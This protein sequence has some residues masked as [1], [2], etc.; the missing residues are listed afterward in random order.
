MF[1]PSDRT[2]SHSMPPFPP[3]LRSFRGGKGEQQVDQGLHPQQ[4]PLVMRLGC[5]VCH[6]VLE[7]TM[8]GYPGL[9]NVS[10]DLGHPPPHPE[11]LVALLMEHHFN[12]PRLRHRLITQLLSFFL[13]WSPNRCS[14]SS[15]SST[16]Y[17]KNQI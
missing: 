12:E 7:S 13:W 9:P 3:M 17:K 8:D 6:Q 10:M 2:V 14:S 16:T 15:G 4:S 5:H 1:V 11:F